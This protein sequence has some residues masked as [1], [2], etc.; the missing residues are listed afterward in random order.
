MLSILL[1]LV[2]ALL[3]HDPHDAHDGHR[4]QDAEPLPP[5]ADVPAEPVYLGSGP[6]RYRW[7][8]AWLQLPDGREHFGSTHGCIA[9]D[10]RGHVYLSADQGDAIQVFDADGTFVRSFGEDWGGGL[11]GLSIVTERTVDASGEPGTRE[12]LYAAHLGEKRAIKTTLDG[13]LL[14]AFERP[15]SAELYPDPSQ[16]RPTSV[17]VAPDGTV[18]VADGYGLYWIH[19]YAPDGTYRS[20]F[21]G[22][23]EA[24][25]Q[26]G[27]PHGLWIDTRGEAPTLIVAD[28]AKSRLARFSLAGEY[29][30]QTDPASG[31]LR[32]PCHLQFTGDLAVVADLQGRITLLDRDL[33]L[34]THL[35]DNPD[36]SQRANFGVTPDAWSAGHFTA[37][38]CARIAPDGSIYVM[39]WN[40]AGRLTR[41]VP[42]PE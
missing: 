18:F 27:T 17:A 23:G 3:P 31:L 41:L 4:H 21:G 7:D 39:D 15:E 13:E 9:I 38:H 6:H 33:A 22:R 19:V 14:V 20:S 11:H 8:A 12:V 30:S 40:V 24:L 42:A 28:R 37:P 34:V 26:L 5:R 1:P 35:G 29:L 10:S 25:E 2:G 36:E 32:R 16:Y